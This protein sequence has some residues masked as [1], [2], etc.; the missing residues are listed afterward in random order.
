MNTDAPLP[1]LVQSDATLQPYEG[2][3]RHRRDRY[4]SALAQIDGQGGLLG[5][6]SQ[7]HDYFGFHRG[8]RAGRPGVWYREWAPAAHQLFL[9][10]D[11]NG[12]D[13]RSHPLERG[14]E[15]VWTL[16]LPDV[17]G[18]N[19]LAHGSQVKVHV[20]S[21]IGAMDR[22]PLYARRVVQDPQTK[23]FAAQIWLPPVPYRFEH[24]S[25]HLKQGLRIYEAHVGMATEEY[26]VG[27]F[28]EFT[29]DLVPRIKALGYN[30]IQLMAVM[31]H[32]YYASFGYHVSSFFAVSSRFGTPEE[33][34]QLI[35]AAHAAGLLVLM[36]LVHS[37][38]VKNT[39]EGLDLF[40]GTS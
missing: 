11:F 4:V 15:G 12:W 9:T 39:Q 5:P 32:P 29:A 8:E 24:A 10:G 13:R 16:F 34:K 36:D 6:I 3:V 28:A 35:D 19:P 22:I 26:K 14:A 23:G 40:D 30:A 18:V 31:E 33:L 7:G 37:H 1:A 25:P 2:A 21:G 38:A 17:D 27:T 20:L